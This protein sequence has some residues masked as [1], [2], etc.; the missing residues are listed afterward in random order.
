[1]KEKWLSWVL[2]PLKFYVAIV[3]PAYFICRIFFFYD[4]PITIHL[5]D[6]GYTID[7][8]T[9]GILCFYMFCGLCLLIGGT[10]QLAANRVGPAVQTLLLAFVPVLF[11][12][13]L[14]FLWVVAHLL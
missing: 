14:L 4:N 6:N 13:A 5:K 12:F 9:W 1:M 2:N 7:N 11:L 10:F 3:V 8:F